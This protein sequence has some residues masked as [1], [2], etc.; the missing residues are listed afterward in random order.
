MSIKSK[1]LIVDDEPRICKSIKTL[2]HTQGY[3]VQICHNGHEAIACFKKNSFDLILQDIFMEGMDGFMVLDAMR[4]QNIETPVIMMTG[5]ASTRSAVKAMKIGAND[6]IKKPFEPDELFSLIK[7]TLHQRTLEIEN[8]TVVKK[9]NASEKKF[10]NLV[11]SSNDW[12]YEIN[13]KGFYTYAS[14]QVKDILGYTPEEILGKTLFDILLPEEIER[15]ANTF[16]SLMKNPC[17]IQNFEKKCLHKDGHIVILESNGTPFFDEVGV[18]EGFRGV[19]RDITDRKRAERALRDEKKFNDLAIDSLPGIF[20]FF[21]KE[22]KFLRWNKNFEKVLGYTAVEI[23]TM[24]PRDFFPVEEQGIVE[25]RIGEAFTDGDS[26]VEA[27]LLSKSG[28]KTL[29]YLTGVR[30]KVKGTHCQ[31]GVGI[32]ISDRKRAERDRE[33]LHAQLQQS[34]KMESI[35]NLAGGIAHDFNNLLFPIIGMSEMLLE[36][37]PEDS[38]EHENAQD[39]FHA[40]RRAA[41]LVNQ[42]LAFSRQSEHKM[43]PVRV[44]N[45]LK[46]LLKLSRSTIPANIDIQ[47]NIQQNCGL[48]LAD[49]TQIHQVAMNLITNAFHAVE[50][51]NGTI[52]IELKEITLQDNELP[53]SALQSGQYVKLSVSDNGIGMSQNI[54]HNIFE[55]YFTTKKQGKGTGLGL[56]VVYGILTE[57]K[58]DIKVYSEVGKGTTFEV[59]LPLMNKSAEAIS[60]ETVIDEQKGTERLLLVDDEESVV[61]L[62]KQ[63]LERLGYT[64]SAFSYSLEALE[65]FKSNPDSYDLVISDMT[66]PNMTGDQL[67]LELMSVRPDIP[68]IICTGYSERINK[69]QSEANKV[70]GF[71]IK[72]V[73]KSEMAQMV[74]KVLDD[75][76]I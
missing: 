39:I 73:V 13:A 50:E 5:N 35:G 67:A 63:M 43:V 6:Y 40:G 71:L 51:K 64:V 12:I 53:D 44:Q 11:E 26:F 69:E 34:Q 1:I 33:K 7:S 62:E 36:D 60:T 32:D 20:Y 45:V 23:R 59:H 74:R 4:K 19:K 38:P 18:L 10:R 8:K 2:L 22:G 31:V 66:M 46:E 17:V 57:Y 52:N 25:E 27:N 41:T 21:T 15:V 42:I 61:R 37:L 48:I 49:P 29:Y 24:Q 14:P 16:N 75:S 76:K 58:G 28:T 65:A 30:V 68:V 3:E 56:A 54:S 70:K 55:P 72:P 47:Q 9:L